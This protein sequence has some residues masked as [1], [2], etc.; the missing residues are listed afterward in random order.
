M[1]ACVK[2]HW[3]DAGRV[4]YRPVTLNCRYKVQ[5]AQFTCIIVVIYHLR[6]YCRSRRL[7]RGRKRESNDRTP[8]STCTEPE[9][10][11]EAERTL[12]LRRV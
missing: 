6:E 2:F 12:I 8:D 3:L 7:Y 10:E 1:I 9:P 11:A 4:D 5:L